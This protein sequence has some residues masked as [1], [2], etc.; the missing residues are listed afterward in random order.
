[1][2]RLIQVIGCSTLLLAAA[3]ARADFGVPISP[4][5]PLNTN[6][7]GDTGFDGSQHLATDGQGNWIAVW[8][9]FNAIPGP[10][11]TDRDIHFARTID[12]GENWSNPL[13]L[14]ANFATETASDEYPVIATDGKGNWVAVWSAV[15]SGG[16]LGT[17]VDLLV[18]RSIDNGANWSIPIPLNTNATTDTGDDYT[19]DVATDGQGHWVV[20]WRSDDTLGG[21]IGSD[22]DMLIARSINNGASWTNPVP[23]NSNAGTDS[24][25]DSSPRLVTDCKGNWLAA[26]VSTNTLGATPPADGDIHFVRSIDN[27]EHWSLVA[28]LNTNASSDSGA[29]SSIQ[30]A[31]DGQDNWVAVWASNDALG[32]TIGADYDL[33]VARSANHGASWSSPAPLNNDAAVDSD[34]DTSP[35]VATDKAGRWVVIWDGAGIGGPPSNDVDVRIARSIDNGTHWSNPDTFNNNAANDSAED[36]APILVTDE[37]G[38]WLAVWE[39]EDPPGVGLRDDGDILTQHFA[40]PDCNKN[41]IADSTEVLLGLLPDINGNNIPDVCEII[42]GP[43][44]GQPNGCGG[45]VCGVGMAPAVPFLLLGMGRM[46][47]SRRRGIGDR[48]AGS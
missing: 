33:L 23:L 19:P 17:D 1:M 39:T 8:S 30:L 7:A 2:N 4:V 29:D 14:N 20:V 45:G 10:G 26:W 22:T 44:P 24:G 32:G 18:A 12:N 34:A 27:G 42:D 28:A 46:R 21:T 15:N 9:S 41:L 48:N 43:P 40:L 37:R 47:R 31:C 35:F 25:V 5:M 3:S 36:G 16:T 11:T 38:S 13:P 6:A